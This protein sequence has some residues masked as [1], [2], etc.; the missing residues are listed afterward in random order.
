MKKIIVLLALVGIFGVLRAQDIQV[1]TYDSEFDMTPASFTVGADGGKFSFK[2]TCDQYGG[3]LRAEAD[4]S[5]AETY[6]SAPPLANVSGFEYIG[7]EDTAGQVDSV[8]CIFTTRPLLDG[9]FVIFKPNETY[10]KKSGKLIIHHYTKYAFG[11]V[12]K[13]ERTIVASYT[14]EANPNVPPPY[15]IEHAMIKNVYLDS[16]GTDKVR[17]ITYYDEFERP[18]QT[19]QEGASPAGGDIVHFT[20]YDLMGRSDAKTYLPYAVQDTPGAKRTDP[21]G[22]QYAYYAAKFTNVGT[23]RVYAEKRYDDSPLNLVLSEGGVGTYNCSSG[24]HTDYTYRLNTVADNIKTYAIENDSVLVVKGFYPADRLIVKLTYN[25]RAS[26]DSYDRTSIEYINSKG[27]L[28]AK[29]QYVSD[30]DRRISYYVYDEYGRQRFVIPAIMDAQMTVG[31]RRTPHSLRLY[32]YYN[33]YDEE[34]RIVRQ[35][36]PGADYV[37]SLYDGR[38][39]LAMTQDGNLRK[40]NKWLFT[41]YDINDRPVMTG[42][43]TGGTYASHKSALLSQSS[44]YEQRGS[45]VHG[46]T[47]RTYPSVSAQN[48]YLTVTYYDDYAWNSSTRYDFASSAALGQ[49][50]TTAVWGLETGKKTRALGDSSNKWLTTVNY[51]D[52]RQRLIQ[53]LTDLYPD[54]LETVTNVHDFSGRVIRTRVCQTKPNDWSIIRPELRD[55]SG[56]IIEIESNVYEYDKWFTYDAYGRLQKIEME[57][58]GDDNGKVTVAAYEY[59]DLGTV[60]EKKIHNGKETT[61]YSRLISGELTSAASPSFS[62]SLYYNTNG[63]VKEVG[64]NYGNDSKKYYYY[65]YNSTDE[66]IASALRT[67]GETSTRYSEFGITYDLNG[68]MLSLQRC[69]GSGNSMHDIAY[70]YS[71]NQLTSVR[72]TTNG[73]TLTGFTYDANG[74]MTYDPTKGVGIEYNVLNLPQR[75]FAGDEE[76][77]YIYSAT[78][79][80][81]AKKAGGSFTYYRSVMVYSGDELLYIL[82]PEGTVSHS[83]GRFTYNYFKSDH[84]GSTRALLSAVGGSLQTQQTTDYYPFGMAWSLNNLNKNK[85]LYSGKEIEDATLAGNVLALYDFGARFYNPV[86]GRWFNM[87]PKLQYA[88]PYLF[89]SN[90]PVMYVDPDGQFSWL[91]SALVGGAMNLCANI[92]NVDNFWDGLGYFFVGAGAAA[93][94][95]SISNGIMSAYMGTGFFPGFWGNKVAMEAIKHFQSSFFRGFIIGG[96]SGLGGGFVFG[97]G[98]G[99]L[100]GDSFRQGLNRGISNSL[101]EGGIGALLGGALGGIQAGLDGRNFF[102]GSRTHIEAQLPPTPT[103]PD[104]NLPVKLQENPEVGCVQSAGGSMAE[105]KGV[106][107]GHLTPEGATAIDVGKQLGMNPEQILVSDVATNMQMGNPVMITYNNAGPYHAVGLNKVFLKIPLRGDPF[108]IYQVMDP[109]VGMRKAPQTSFID[110]SYVV[111]K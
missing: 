55:V 101:I 45:A 28:V 100:N 41:K 106:P 35:C 99:W 54:Q 23:D 109:L 92:E 83:D 7:F 37:L 15:E 79:E 29:E 25:N 82:H 39:R 107:A 56:G 4:T 42:I 69:D 81:L 70:G 104:G 16:T 24:Y 111:F 80:K 108:R 14:Q 1:P 90:N 17:E 38:G 9:S 51:Y 43:Y 58:S 84:T 68:N 48:D 64:W 98:N 67:Q 27:Q 66:L 94:S 91:I 87:D 3:L 18:Y 2:L 53:T 33:E 40:Q 110:A 77:C 11:S 63:S 61:E 30:T 86:L 46:Y 102:D 93:L 5:S 13:R 78:G 57:I 26:D 105:Y 50:Y 73:Q 103:A 72:M 60:T 75:I 19:I 65:A 12:T 31:T 59:D 22:E 20:E 96:A 71:G 76:V 32:C 88:N 74:N 62:Y 47:N 21:I 36:M 89:C 95:T 8:R 6:A 85:Y 44:L 52:D 97:A 34:G 10:E 49:T